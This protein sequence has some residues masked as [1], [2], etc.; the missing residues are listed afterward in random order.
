MKGNLFLSFCL[1]QKSLPKVEKSS[2]LS[3]STLFIKEQEFA[4]IIMTR[5]A[6]G[7]GKQAAQNQHIVFHLITVS[8][9][10][11]MNRLWLD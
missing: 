3:F 7:Q 1:V 9:I 2:C 10:C 11:F 4:N 8:A 5:F 6:L